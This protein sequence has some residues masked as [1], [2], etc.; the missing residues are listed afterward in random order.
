MLTRA[1]IAD[2]Q[3]DKPEPNENDDETKD[4]ENKDDETKDEE[5]KDDE[6]KEDPSCV[7][8]RWDENSE[9]YVPCKAGTAECE[10]WR[11]TSNG[12]WEECGGSDE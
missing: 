1:S 11:Q 3:Q 4:D 12:D 6:T 10:G 5:N 9:N 7:F 2:D 8:E